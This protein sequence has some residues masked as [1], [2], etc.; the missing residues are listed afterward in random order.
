MAVAMC[1]GG[2]QEALG[3][4]RANPINWSLPIPDLPTV[5]NSAAVS[6]LTHGLDVMYDGRHL[7]LYDVQAARL[8]VADNSRHDDGLRT[9]TGSMVSGCHT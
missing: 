5:T 6:V 7:R 9:E 1:C 8:A 4:R 3:C 2:K